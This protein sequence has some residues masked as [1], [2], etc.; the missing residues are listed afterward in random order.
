MAYRVDPSLPAA[1]TVVKRADYRPPEFL[2]D[3]V[4][5]HI[6]IAQPLVTVHNV[7]A[8]RRNPAGKGKGPLVLEGEYQTL[9]TIIVDGHALAPKEYVLTPHT[10][11]IK[12]PPEAGVVEV[13]STHDPHKNTALSGLYASGGGML[14]T[15]MEPEGFRRFT[16]YPDRPDVLATFTTRI[17]ADAKNYPVLLSNGNLIKQGKLAGGRHF[18]EWEDPHP[19]PCYLFA[20]V[21]GK[22]AVV[23][24]QFQTRSGRKVAIEFYVMAGQEKLTDIARKALKDAMAW[25]ERAYGLEYD[26]D[27]FMVVAT[28]FFNMGAMENKGLNIFNSDCVLADP[29]TTTDGDIEFVERVVAHEYFHN[30]TGN[31]ITCRDW[32]QLSLKEGLTVFREQQF[33]EQQHDVALMRVAE[34]RGLRSR[35][36]AEDAGPTAHPVRPDQYQSIDN[37]YTATVYEK[38]AE[39]CR[40][41]HTLVGD[42]GWRMGMQTYVQRHDGQAATCDQFVAAMAD[43]NRKDFAQFMR[44]YSQAG[45]P[46]LYITTKYDARKKVS[47]LMVKQTCPP[48]PGQAKKQPFHLP[49]SVG[50]L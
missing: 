2:V 17:E 25:D 36:F 33:M 44:W 39:V 49:L 32:F 31:R 28:P 46:T 10:L 11:T 8:L 40:M 29:A 30:W 7:M 19:K 5:L 13:I 14:N 27:R 21:A 45:T 24:D 35:Q 15:Q 37:F 42:A 4:R 9:Q 20:L 34:V 50:L 47:Q 43:A 26:L 38:G 3:H 48:T 16:Y 6:N 23:K 41:L 12:K 1:P 18:A 22:L